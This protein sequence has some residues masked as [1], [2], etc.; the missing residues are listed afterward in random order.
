MSDN[1]AVRLRTS[2]AMRRVERE[3]RAL[4]VPYLD[5]MLDDISKILQP[6]VHWTL[7]HFF[8]LLTEHMSKS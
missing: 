7:A 1:A 2:N 5:A 8:A 6:S 4:P 3:N